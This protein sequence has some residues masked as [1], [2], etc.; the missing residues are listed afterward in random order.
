MR[1]LL[2]LRSGVSRAQAG[3]LLLLGLVSLRH[4]GSS[5]AVCAGFSWWWFLLFWSSGCRAHEQLWHMAL[6]APRRVESSQARDQ[7]QAP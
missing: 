4:V 1:W 3:L 2:L 7:T 6:V 5:L